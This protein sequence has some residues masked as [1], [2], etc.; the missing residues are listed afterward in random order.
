MRA[1]CRD[2]ERHGACARCGT[3]VCE[4]CMRGIAQRAHRADCHRRRG[5]RPSTQASLALLVATIG[6]AGFVPGIA[7]LP[8]AR[9]ELA[10]LIAA[11]W[12]GFVAMGQV[13]EGE[14]S[15]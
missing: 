5:S 14:A 1:Q 10:I 9:R 15:P 13:T 4:A 8:L 12:R 2:H 3:F 6:F 11:M 7:A